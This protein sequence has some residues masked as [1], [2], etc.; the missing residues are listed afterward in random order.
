MDFHILT[1]AGPEHICSLVDGQV[2]IAPPPVQL[3]PERDDP[4]E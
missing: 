4:A 3:E 2:V 1:P